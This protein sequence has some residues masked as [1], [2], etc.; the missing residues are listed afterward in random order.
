MYVYMY[1]MY[2]YMQDV[3]SRFR[4]VTVKGCTGL[5]WSFL[6][7]MYFPAFSSPLIDLCCV[8]V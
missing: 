6:F 2:I 5:S 4:K 3:S 8:A 7:A 1:S